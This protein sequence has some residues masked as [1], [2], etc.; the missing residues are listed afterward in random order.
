MIVVGN[1][2]NEGYKVSHM[3][4]SRPNSLKPEIA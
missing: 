3:F 4:K 2:E 1:K